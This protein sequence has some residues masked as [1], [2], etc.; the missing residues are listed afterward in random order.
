MVQAATRD[1][2]CSSATRLPQLFGDLPPV[3]ALNC[4]LKADPWIDVANG[5]C[6]A[7]KHSQLKSQGH[8]VCWSPRWLSTDPAAYKKKHYLYRIASRK[9]QRNWQH[10]GRCM[11]PPT[12]NLATTAA[13]AEDHHHSLTVLIEFHTSVECN[14]MYAKVL[15]LFQLVRPLHCNLCK[16]VFHVLFQLLVHHGS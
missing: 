7:E 5:I 13:A 1:R 2:E 14:T 8:F 3:L 9:L 12:A 11:S 16:P 6:K 4:V 10:S 15:V